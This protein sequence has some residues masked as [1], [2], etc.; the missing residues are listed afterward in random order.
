MVD[1]L[2]CDKGDSITPD[3]LYYDKGDTN[4]VFQQISSIVTRAIVLHQIFPSIS[5]GFQVNLDF[6]Q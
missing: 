2:Y 4:V 6:I 3:F 1:S 5:S